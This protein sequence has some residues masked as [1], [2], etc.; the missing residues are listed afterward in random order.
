MLTTARTPRSTAQTISCCA[1][2]IL[3]FIVLTGFGWPLSILFFTAIADALIYAGGFAWNPSTLD[4]VYALTATWAALTLLVSLTGWATDFRHRAASGALMRNV[5]M[6]GTS[7]CA[8][9]AIVYAA[10]WLSEHLERSP[11]RGI[12][13]G[14]ALA[15]IVAALVTCTHAA[16]PRPQR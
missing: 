5:L 1:D 11:A 4:T 2:N 9:G 13:V 3:A 16:P 12:I 6:F 10:L 7:Y 14:V 15:G 8:L